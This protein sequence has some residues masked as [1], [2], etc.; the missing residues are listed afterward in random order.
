MITPI[1]CHSDDNIDRLHVNLMRSIV[2]EGKDLKFGDK[3]EVKMAREGCFIIQV[4]GK[5]IN[6]LLDGKVPKG[7]PFKKSMVKR[8]QQAF[9]D[10]ETNPKDFVYT[11]Q[12]LL[13][14]WP[15]T[16]FRDGMIKDG[17]DHLKAG[18]CTI[19]Y[20]QM[21]MAKR[22]LKQDVDD[23]ICSNRNVGTTLHPYMNDVFD[24]V[25]MKDKPCFNWFQVRYNGNKKVS[26]RLLFRS[27]DYVHGIW[28]NLCSVVKAFY[29][30]VVKPCGCEIEE[31]ILISTSGHAY[32][33]DSEE[34]EKASGMKWERELTRMPEIQR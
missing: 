19:V 15:R 27:H 33:S 9:L 26:I 1:F 6:R 13:K 5:G 23:D 14:E 17:F 34:A 28:P 10:V 20:D 2:F 4:Y 11:Y 18:T 30:L 16:G 12:Q 22:A 7:V 21:K 29:E 3:T 32:E 24:G 25:E 31:V 8:L